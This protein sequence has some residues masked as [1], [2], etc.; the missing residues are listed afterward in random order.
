MLRPDTKWKLKPTAIPTI[1][2]YHS[3][4]MEPPV[5]VTVHMNEESFAQGEDMTSVRRRSKYRLKV[6]PKERHSEVRVERLPPT[7][8][9]A[10]T[11]YVRDPNPQSSKELSQP[12]TKT[13]SKSPP[14]TSTVPGPTDSNG[15]KDTDAKTSKA[16][17]EFNMKKVNK[18]RLHVD[19]A[20]ADTPVIVKLID[21]TDYKENE[22]HS[23]NTY[24]RFEIWN[25][26]EPVRRPVFQQSKHH[27]IMSLLV[28]N[29]H[30][31]CKKLTP[32]TQTALAY[33]ANRTTLWAGDKLREVSSPSQVMVYE[34]PSA[35]T[36]TS[37]SQSSPASVQKTAN[38]QD[39]AAASKKAYVIGL[40]TTLVG[41]FSLSLPSG[42]DK[43]D[44]PASE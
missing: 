24:L 44:N 39:P 10:Q 2:F 30:N 9:T 26:N 28:N 40:P 8:T 13:T 5:T 38:T 15:S 19:R 35:S 41:P 6:D 32:D 27:R 4:A 1:F 37:S 43:R 42:L 7:I 22:D 21:Q 12:A 25:D 29:S 20:T 14:P 11:I 34:Q 23:Y 3:P 18:V 17:E 31:Y 33:A 16:A 36:L